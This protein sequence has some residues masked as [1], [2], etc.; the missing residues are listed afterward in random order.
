MNWRFTTFILL[1]SFIGFTSVSGQNFLDVNKAEFT[2]RLPERKNAYKQIKNA[3]LLYSKGI[4]FADQSLVL[5][6]EAHKLNQINPELNYNIGI[7]Y[8][9]A[10]PKDKALPF[11]IDAEKLNPDVSED[12]HFLL[13]LAYQ[14]QNLFSKAITHFKMNIELVQLNKY[15]DQKELIA[16]SKKH[17]VECKSGKK[18]QT[19]ETTFQIQLADKVNSIYDDFNPQ[20]FN[21]TLYFSSRREDEKNSRS[22]RDQKYYERIYVTNIIGDEFGTVDKLTVDIANKSSVALM[23]EINPFQFLF[24]NGM[25]GNGDL[26]YGEKRNSEWKLRKELKSINE[27]DSRESSACIRGNELYFVSDRKNGF[28]E[29]DIYVSRKEESGKWGKPINIGGDINTE[30]DEGDV[31]VTSDGQKMFFSS[32]GHNTIGGYDI[33]RCERL[34]SGEWGRP[35]NMGIPINSTDNDITYFENKEGK[36][37]FASERSGG[38]GGF[39]IYAEKIPDP[40]QKVEPLELVELEEQPIPVIQANEP[41]EVLKIPVVKRSAGIEEVAM[42]QELV[43]EDFVYRVQIAAC[44][45]EMGPKDLFKRYKGGAVIEHLYVEEW[46]KYTIGGFETFEEAAKYRDDCG[47]KDAFVVLFKGGYRLGIARKVGGVN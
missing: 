35:Q 37:F 43:E 29:C 13:G 16:L 21:D 44:K 31:F 34:E 30:Y 12:I 41:I 46:H 6:L 20:V 36:F 5:L 22:P 47:V 38:D 15:K 17:I 11:L 7:C 4:G 42:N 27:K 25:V 45:K 28:G 10:G 26:F 2:E 32:R 24:F 19:E 33:F 18:L 14:Y 40:V 23:S 39:D 3:A 1:L 8:L 9:I